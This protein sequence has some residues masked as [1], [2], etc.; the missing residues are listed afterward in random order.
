MKSLEPKAYECYYFHNISL[1]MTLLQIF[2]K[3]C[4]IELNSVNDI[5]LIYSRFL[6]SR[7]VKG[8]EYLWSV[9]ETPYGNES[10]LS[11]EQQP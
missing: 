8:C 7:K 5:G 1:Q 2:I 10:G 11:R 9:G 6:F 4:I 3:I